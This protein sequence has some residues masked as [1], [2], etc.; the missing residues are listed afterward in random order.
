MGAAVIA[1]MSCGTQEQRVISSPLPQ[2]ALHE[3]MRGIYQADSRIIPPQGYAVRA[4]I[5]PHHLTA[6]ETIASG[7]AML[8]SEERKK[9]L[10]LSP[11]HFQRCPTL[12]CTAEG[13][14]RTPLG[15]LEVDSAS[16][17]L[18][19]DSPFISTEENLFR[20]E[21]GIGA[22]LPYIAHYHPTAKIVPL[23]LSL[24]HEWFDAREDLVRLL[25]GLLDEDTVLLVSS[26]FS[27][28]LSLEEAEEKDE[29]TAKAIFAGDLPGIA[30]LENPG[31]SDCPRC[32]WLL[33]RIAQEKN[34]SNPSVVLHTN[35]ASILKEPDI[36][37]TTSHFAIVFYENA[38]LRKTDL[39]FGGDVTLTR[40]KGEI[41]TLHPEMKAFWEGGGVRVV[42]LEGPLRERCGSSSNE[43]I[44]C[45]SAEIWRT[46]RDVATHWGTL[47][48]H[49]YDQGDAG[50]G[51]SLRLL[52]EAEE[53]ALSFEGYEDADLRI[54][55]VTAVMNPV[56]DLFPQPLSRQYE[57][58]IGKLEDQTS[59]KLTVVFVHYGAEYRA[60]ITE[61]DRAF[62]R[63]F[64]DAGADAVIGAH[65]HVVSDM[66]IYKGKPIFHSL[67]NFLFDQG[68]RV[69]TSTAL[70]V[71]LRREGDRVLF[72]TLSTRQ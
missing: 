35:S 53:E 67:G 29:E 26:D 46:I 7:I 40:S 66:E 1:L 55:P 31:Q 49:M 24:E 27:H 54:F 41:P 34:F 69:S 25:S 3:L 17:A 58:V 13:I 2:A 8:M 39:A 5:V 60:L 12:L 37:E 57:T 32:L 68:D 36:P 18:L 15:D 64:I 14:F 20:E 52:E 50:Y 51:E 43:Y 44:F 16:V 63:S 56:Q 11:D 21:H 4:A 47:N 6:T 19:R 28:Y 45:N 10:L 30:A 23:V 9:I 22:V 42:N 65:S 59:E 33:L 38:H 48:N 72:E 62:L 61:E 71:R 70:A